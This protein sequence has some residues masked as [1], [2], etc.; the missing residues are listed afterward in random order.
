M[1]LPNSEEAFVVGS[2]NADRRIELYDKD[3][4]VYYTMKH[5]NLCTITSLNT[6][7]PRR[8]AL[9][10]CNSSGKVVVFTPK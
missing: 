1:W 10:G 7:H 2:M 3:M 4:N 6:F 8:P 5:E 9:A